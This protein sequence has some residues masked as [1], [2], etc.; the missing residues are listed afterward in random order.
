MAIFSPRLRRLDDALVALPADSDAMLLSELDGYLAGVIVCP[1]LILPGEWL[2]RV[3]S[4]DADAAPFADE[5]EAR[6]YVELVMAQHN[7]IVRTL[8]KRNGRYAPVFEVDPRHDEVLWELWVEGFEAAKT[9]RPD[10]WTRL[11]VGGDDDAAEAL[12]GMITLG[13]IARDESDLERATIDALTE[14]AP[15][16]IPLWVEAL[17]N[18]RLEHGASVPAAAPPRADKVGRND[19]CRCGSGRKSKKCCGLD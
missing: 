3:W 7:A 4:S 8:G 2:P 6:W 1:E 11:A 15:N 19:P 16:L 10:S 13:Q 5:L 17:N 12:A 14:E 18:F 9:L